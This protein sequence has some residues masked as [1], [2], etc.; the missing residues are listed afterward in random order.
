MTEYIT[1]QINGETLY[2]EVESTDR[3]PMRGFGSSGAPCRA[4]RWKW[5]G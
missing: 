3:P 2:I 4:A 5:K 1:T